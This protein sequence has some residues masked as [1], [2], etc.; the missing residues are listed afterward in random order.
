MAHEFARSLSSTPEM[1][2]REHLASLLMGVLNVV[3]LR[4]IEEQ[5]K[6]Q[7]MHAAVL[8]IGE[9]DRLTG[10][11]PVETLLDMV[12][13]AVHMTAVMPLEDS[14][15]YAPALA[16]ATAQQRFL[17]ER[18]VSGNVMVF[19]GTAVPRGGPW[20]N[21][22][23]LAQSLMKEIDYAALGDE[24]AQKLFAF[25]MNKMGDRRLLLERHLAYYERAA[26][27]KLFRRIAKLNWTAVFTTLQ[28]EF[29]EEAYAGLDR[30]VDIILSPEKEPCPESGVTPIYKIYGTL[31]EEHK[32]DPAH[33]LPITEYDYRNRM[34][35][36]QEQKFWQ[37]IG[38]TLDEGT[39][40]L[41][42]CATEDELMAAYGQYL[43]TETSGLI[44]MAGGAF[45]EE[46]QDVYRNL[47]FRVLPDH[48]SE[49]LTVL[50]SL[51]LVEGRV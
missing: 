20:P 34:T 30:P 36:T 25:Y 31:N 4:H 42:L 47:N 5:R 1:A 21:E 14:G 28:H 24:K 26:R 50:Y 35:V 9:L 18:L 6:L 27:P 10:R 32:N 3:R 48:P 8:I 33:Q 11:A 46:E 19:M 17:A 23:H 38:R 39:S 41:M 51:L 45:S 2:R 40:L 49:L 15:F 29:L 12:D 16:M 7:A 22:G 44:W 43:P 13:D 37:K